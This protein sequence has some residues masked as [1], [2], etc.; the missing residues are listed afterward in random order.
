MS[1]DSYFWAL[2]QNTF[3][4]S[5]AR[6]LLHFH[7]SLYV[8][9]SDTVDFVR[10]LVNDTMYCVRV[11]FFH[12]FSALCSVKRVFFLSLSQSG[13]NSF[14]AASQ[15][16]VSVCRVFVALAFIYYHKCCCFRVCQTFIYIFV[17]FY[18]YSPP[19]FLFARIIATIFIL[20]LLSVFVVDI[21]AC[22][23]FRWIYLVVTYRFTHTRTMRTF[24][25]L[26]FCDEWND[27]HRHYYCY[28]RRR[29]RHRCR[30]HCLF[31][32]WYE[33]VILRHGLL[34]CV[35]FA[36]NKV[37]MNFE[38]RWHKYMHIRCM[39]HFL[40]LSYQMRSNSLLLFANYRLRHRHIHTNPWLEMHSQNKIFKSIVNW[41]CFWNT[42]RVIKSW[43]KRTNKHHSLASPPPP[44]PSYCTH[45][46]H[47]QTMY[48]WIN[49]GTCLSMCSSSKHKCHTTYTIPAKSS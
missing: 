27:D 32:T 20:S 47:I 24:C 28:F 30:S 33:L 6:R 17:A 44:L 2:F 25:S 16:I 37:T 12:P 4:F 42:Q 35:H 1:D 46:Y 7:G 49:E 19:F 38:M 18:T 41:D 29:H 40:E 9:H 48:K 3:F 36:S 43:S 23:V 34:C 10:S 15:A 39:A 5:L 26:K 31:L 8:F 22:A 14:D 13:F 45:P 21:V 11:L